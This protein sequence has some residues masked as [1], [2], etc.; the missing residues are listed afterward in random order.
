MVKRYFD[1]WIRQSLWYANDDQY[2]YKFCQA[3]VRY[4]KR[5]GLRKG[6]RGRLSEVEVKESILVAWR[7]KLDADFLEDRANHYASLFTV[8]CQAFLTPFP[9][10]LIEK[11]SPVYT[12]YALYRKYGPEEQEQIGRIMKEEWGDG[13]ESKVHGAGR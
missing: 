5:S 3:A 6:T 10:M 12:Y 13:W 7:G 11:R 1:A 4:G 2:F 9:D 8:I